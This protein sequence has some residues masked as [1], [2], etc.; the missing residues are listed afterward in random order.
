MMEASD[1]RSFADDQLVGYR[2][3][4]YEIE[5]S[6]KLGSSVNPVRRISQLGVIELETASG[7]CGFGVFEASPF[8][9]ELPP[10]EELERSFRSLVAPTLENLH[11]Q[12]FVHRI[13]LRPRGGHLR[14][15]IFT[16]AV[17]QAVWDIVAKQAG[18][19]LW[20]LLGG[21]TPLVPVYASA[22][23]YSLSTTE[24]TELI[25]DFR[26][27]GLTS[28]KFKIGY[29]DEAWELER[30]LAAWEAVGP[31][32]KLLIDANEAWSPKEAIRRMHRFHDAGIEVYWLEDPCLR[33]DFDGIAQVCREVPF[34]LINTGENLDLT[35]KRLLLERQAVDVLN[36]HG[37]YSETIH[38]A[39]L[40]ADF[41][42]PITIGNVLLDMSAPLAAALPSHTMMEYSMTGEDAIL[43][44]PF[45][46]GANGLLHL[47]DVPGHG[48][49]L[50]SEARTQLTKTG[51]L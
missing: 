46:L 37:W 30:L 31:Q 33:E 36:L 3:G 34:S 15:L 6:R 28:V 26:K 16:Q 7:L 22:H 13:P 32:G 14:R 24:L 45:A 40:A 19:P 20:R 44:E 10:L 50:N 38:A 42:I 2:V 47:H 43:E 39:R 25:A 35:G 18:I 5:T 9:S 49:A 21:N 8:P 4:R 17:D 12:S 11:P 29:D 27:R 48:L 41:G 51:T 23:D 1:H